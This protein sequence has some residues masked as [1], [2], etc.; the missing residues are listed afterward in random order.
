MRSSRR[1]SW[2]GFADMAQWLA[3]MG[4]EECIDRALHPVEMVAP[5]AFAEIF[6]TRVAEI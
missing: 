1:R 6:W 2:S 3:F 4:T 5:V